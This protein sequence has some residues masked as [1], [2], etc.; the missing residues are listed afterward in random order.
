[1]A[2]ATTTAG[3]KA[4]AALPVTSMQEVAAAGELVARSGMLGAQTPAE[5]F[6]VVATCL[7]EKI[8]F[9]QFSETYNIIKG[10]IA[11]KSEAMLARLLSL[12]GEYEVI[13]HT[14]ERAALKLKY[15]SAEYLSDVT[16]EEIQKETFTRK[17]DGK[18]L[19]DNWS[20]PRRRAQMMWARAVSDG[21]RVV[22]PLASRGSYTPEEVEDFD[23]R[24]APRQAVPVPVEP[25]PMIPPA[26]SA[27]PAPAL[28][29]PVSVPS[30]FDKPIAPAEAEQV[31]YTVCRATGPYQGKKW[32]EIETA[33]LKLALGIS[34]PLIADGDR[35][36]INEILKKREARQ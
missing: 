33:H 13:S 21:V 9:L 8:S 7:Q 36:V 26:T 31:D 20:T 3:T 18:T 27:S 29:A 24:P 32:E 22:C 25:A 15:K 5:G 30:P 4:A 34:T 28:T 11:I 1:M 2:T 35:A 10:K 23:E 16:W 12:G 6:L 14:P 17:A 19:K